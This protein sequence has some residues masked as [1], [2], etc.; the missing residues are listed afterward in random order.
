MKPCGFTYYY[1][2]PPPRYTVFKINSFYLKNIKVHKLFV[3]ISMH[4]YKV[5]HHVTVIKMKK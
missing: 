1:N 2:Q 3:Y 4:F 5:N